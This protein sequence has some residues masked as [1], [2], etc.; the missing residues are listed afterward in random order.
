[1]QSRQIAR[2]LALLG[3][4]QL[5]DQP[6]KLAPKNLQELVEAAVKTLSQ[7][8]NEVL[9]AAA[10]ELR[11]SSDSL[12]QS[13]T[14]ATDP[15]EAAQMVKTAIDATQT[16]INQLGSALEL[17]KFIQF[18]NR[19]DVRDYAVQILS[20]GAVH[21]LEIDQRLNDAM[22]AWQMK[23][24]A[25]I[26]R[27]ILRTA[28]IEI[29]YLGL[30]ERVAINEAVELAK[31]YSDEDGHRFINGV[32]RRVTDAST[33]EKKEEK[34]EKAVERSAA[35]ARLGGPRGVTLRDH[36]SP[37]GRSPASPSEQ[38]AAPDADSPSAPPA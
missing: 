1:M 6:T 5:P 38:P 17:P 31:R 30:P 21:R 37:V 10:T 33:A 2:E 14:R 3:L 9:E 32:L 25:R 28:V 23:R 12:I 26:D 27:D 34:A 20:H 7:E 8:A 36:V 16:A 13:E 11:R 24:L 29:Y 15:K 35:K 22:V 18:A 4:G 19:Q